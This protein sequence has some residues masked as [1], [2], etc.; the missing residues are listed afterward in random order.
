MSK[1]T[2]KTD[3][4]RCMLCTK[5]ISDTEIF[6]LAQCYHRCHWWHC[7]C[8]Q[9]LSCC[10]S[11]NAIIIRDKIDDD[12]AIYMPNSFSTLSTFSRSSFDANIILGTAR[13]D[14]CVVQK[15][16]VRALAWIKCSPEWGI[17]DSGG[18]HYNTE[19]LFSCRVHLPY[20]FSITPACKEHLRLLDRSIFHYMIIS[21]YPMY[22][23]STI[24]AVHVSGAHPT[25]VKELIFRHIDANNISHYNHNTMQIKSITKM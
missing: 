15:L 23:F 20:D 17:T 8:E 11:Y 9:S 6:I 24:D 21:A 19:K 25:V 3:L 18:V 16:Y 10:S 22:T 2:S 4:L 1:K 13:E 12:S 14:I 5:E 7:A